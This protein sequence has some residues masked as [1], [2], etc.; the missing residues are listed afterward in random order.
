VWDENDSRRMELVNR[1][2]ET[3]EDFRLGQIV[4]KRSR[5]SSG[6]RETYSELA[7]NS[8]GVDRGDA[9]VCESTE[10]GAGESFCRGGWV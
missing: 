6:G 9:G 4:H 1:R 5:S 10:G 7:A 2:C 3:V 8:A